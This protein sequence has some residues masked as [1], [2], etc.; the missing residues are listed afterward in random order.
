MGFF[1]EPIPQIRRRHR[2]VGFETKEEAVNRRRLEQDLERA[3]AQE[4]LSLAFQPRVSLATGR[5]V[6]AEPSVRWSHRRHGVFSAAALA[7]IA[8]GY[9]LTARLSGFMLTRVCAEAASW[10]DTGAILSVDVTGEQVRKEV[11]LDQV[12]AALER[13][14]LAAERLELELAETSLADMDE[15]AWLA[16]AALRDLGVGLALDHAGMGFAGLATLRRLPFTTLKLD[17]SLVREVVGSQ[18]AGAIV[19]AMAAAGHALGLAV[20]GEGVETAQHR[21]LLARCGCDEGQGNLFGRPLPASAIR[22]LFAQSGGG[23][24]PLSLTLV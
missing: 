13:S 1:G 3:L 22:E 17:R 2:V 21:D 19:L 14:G 24:K 15:D 20:V 8:E 6:G 9:G 11:L 4:A 10:A 5:A 23:L 18:D 16:F 12:G 7:P